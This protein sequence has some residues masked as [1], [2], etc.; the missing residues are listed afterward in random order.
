MA[1]S[2]HGEFFI[3]GDC[4]EKLTTNAMSSLSQSVGAIDTCHDPIM[5]VKAGLARGTVA[6]TDQ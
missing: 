2:S 6:Q 3:R 4:D 1:W 5:L